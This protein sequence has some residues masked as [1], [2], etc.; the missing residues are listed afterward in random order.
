MSVQL[1]TTVR[2]LW[3]QGLDL[4]FPPRCAV[5]QRGGHLLCPP[6]LA[7]MQPLTASLC[8]LCGSP[9][10]EANTL[11]NSCQRHRLTLDGLRFV[12]AYQGP[13]RQAIYALKYRSATRLA[14]PLGLLLA[15]AFRH[16][17]LHA[18]AIA[19]LPLH[20]DRQQQRG[21][22]QS[23]LLARTCAAQLHI[24]YFD[25]LLIR[26]RSTLP[27]VGL[28]APARRQNMAE[29]FIATRSLHSYR[30]LLLIDDV[31]TT[32]ATLEA[33]AATCYAAGVREVWA[34]VLARPIS[35]MYP[36]ASHPYD[37]PSS[38]IQ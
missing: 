2:Q 7:T 33:C 36:P 15:H 23:A 25:N 12:H 26:S 1:Y 34:L 5:C 24:P 29:A 3:Q 18:D 4:L 8:S 28:N 9:L 31:C 32:G 27:Q 17:A 6:C 37:S 11:C 16:Y 35:W 22:N 21:Y 14:H 19:P 10:T 20:R 38:S 30:T 13:L